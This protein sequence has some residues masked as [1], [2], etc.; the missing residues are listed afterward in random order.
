M[1]RLLLDRKMYVEFGL[2]AVLFAANILLTLF[3]PYLTEH[4]RYYDSGAYITVLAIA[5]AIYAF[6]VHFTRKKSASDIAVVVFAFFAIWETAYKT[7]TV[8]NDLLIPSPEGL[9]HV[10][11]EKP[12]EIWLDVLGSLQLL[13]WGF[14]LA[15]LFGTLLGLLAGWIPRIREVLLPI[16]NVITL[17]PPLMFSAYLIMVFATFREAAI[18]VIFFAVFWPTFQGT[19]ARVSQI[20]KAVIEA[21]RTMGVGTIGMLGK[22]I[23]PYCLPGII[24]SISKSLRGAFMCLTGAEM[25]GINLGVGYFI[26]KYKSFADYRCVLAGIVTVGVITT[27]IDIL[28]N[29]AEKALIRWEE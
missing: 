10:F 2:A 25:L 14:F 17:I 27:V 5:F 22:V 12:E 20:D 23:L 26:E 4:K 9:F 13:F 28:V 21:A 15:V 16:S 8:K 6:G 7:G 3:L 24:K 18:A 1:K 29:K 19:V 11:V